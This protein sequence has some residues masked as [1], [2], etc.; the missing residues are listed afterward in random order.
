[1]KKNQLWDAFPHRESIVKIIRVMKLISFFLLA[2]LLE[3][4]ANVYSQN[5]NIKLS[6]HD[7]ALNEIIK[8]IQEQTEFTFFY[9]TDDVKGIIVS[10][11]E[12]KSATLE[13]TLNLSL[14]GTNLDYEIVHKA[15]IIKRR[16]KTRET[17]IDAVAQQQPQKREISGLVKDA[18]GHSLPGASV[19]VKG[20]TMGVI[21]DS[22]GRFKLNIGS[23][24]KILV[25]SFIGMKTQEIPITGK[26][27]IEV[28][29][30]DE[31]VVMNDAVV[32][33]G[34]G[35]QKKV[36]TVAA[37]S[38]V[39]GE[40]LGKISG[41]TNVT[42]QLQGMLP[43]VTI[44][45]NSSKP[46]SNL[47]EIFIRGKA[48]WVSSAILSLVDGVERDFNDVDPNEIETISVLKDASA[49]AVYGV[50][51]AN[52]VILI[53]TKR[54]IFKRPQ[55]SF[56]SSYGWKAATTK[57]VFADYVT[58]MNS[59]NAAATNDKQWN[60]LIPQSTIDAWSNALATNN[61]GP[62][63]LYFPQI[64]WWDQIV[65]T[66]TSQKYNVNIRGGT[67]F[68]KY[69]TSIGYLDNGDIFQTK[70]N[71]LFDPSFGY[72][73]YN[74]RTNLDF[75]LTKSSVLSVNI[76]GYY[77]YRNQ[78]GYRMGVANGSDENT[79]G[80]PAFFESIYTSA[81]N[82]FPINYP[83]GTLGLN[84]VGGGN[85]M[86]TFDMGQRTYKT[87]KN[88]I[89]LAYKQKLDFISKGL[90]FH[91][92]LSYN[93]ESA[94]MSNIVK[95]DGSNFG[96]TPDQGPIGY[97]R[98]YDYSNPLPDGGYA[99][100]A[101]QRWPA[102]YQG[103]NPSASYDNL[104]QGGYQKKLLY[105]FGFDYA[106]SIHK[107]NFTL[108]ALMNRI[109]D[110]GLNGGSTAGM[111][112]PI[113]NESWVSRFTYN[114]NERY[115]LELNGA[116][117]GSQKFAK[118]K[119]FGLFPSYAIGWRVTEEPLLKK[120]IGTKVLTN[121]KIRN[122]SG[123]IGYDQSAPAFTYIQMFN[124]IGG[125]VEFGDVSKYIYGPRYAEGSAANANAT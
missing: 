17:F 107:H 75:N 12:L 108:M 90:N 47:T 99:L 76:S 53:T 92:K 27:N 6:M 19:V 60:K 104:M 125:G 38:Q 84:S 9:S 70:T 106:K 66:G 65:K 85:L 21:T 87:Y 114:W 57:P 78:T 18:N 31:M 94:S 2:G 61:Y 26:T 15:V 14:E 56:E 59:W 69:F 101:S 72:K 43:G 116:Y 3:V 52:G 118:G 86:E 68:V 98:A 22:Y 109:E 124:N 93:T 30:E 105:E 122:S 8:A 62:Y 73:R 97:Y 11:I 45:N 58:A 13:N 16:Q 74:W 37:I 110:R 67:E 117:T 80:Q 54:G 95:Y 102:N 40:A 36:S 46:G 91:A 100:L 115:L 123:I 34:Y 89:D 81:R 44:L 28:A 120:L 96:G 39:S 10:K 121:L 41:L 23:D 32:V 49:T 119:R 79:F 33:V 1:M 5:A 64:D 48:S 77:G 113:N 82:M 88:F 24:D 51:G 63:N 20:S 25:I 35:V 7:V 4:T 111:N 103:N 55:I 112:F 71:E 50:K 83:D 42:E 29:L